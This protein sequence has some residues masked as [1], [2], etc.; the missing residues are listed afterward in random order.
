MNE[1][2]ALRNTKVQE[3]YVLKGNYEGNDYYQAVC[4]LDNGLKLK[5][6]LTAF[7]YKTLQAQNK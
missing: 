4:V 5:T 1:K 2:F 7:E 3:L 6:K